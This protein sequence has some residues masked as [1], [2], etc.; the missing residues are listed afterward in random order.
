MD[1]SQD[2]L[3]YLASDVW[4]TNFLNAYPYYLPA[5]FSLEETKL[6]EKIDP[7]FNIVLGDF[8]NESFDLSSFDKWIKN[9]YDKEIPLLLDNVVYQ[10]ELYEDFRNSIRCKFDKIRNFANLS[11]KCE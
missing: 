7:D 3:A 1:F 6:N 2:F 10:E 5:L 8:Y 9:I 11:A 4:A